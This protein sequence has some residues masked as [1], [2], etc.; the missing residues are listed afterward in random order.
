MNFFAM[1]FESPSHHPPP[2]RCCATGQEGGMRCPWDGIHAASAALAPCPTNRLDTQ[3]RPAE[4]ARH[5]RVQRTIKA[6]PTALHSPCA[7]CRW[8]PKPGPFALQPCLPRWG[9][10]PA[11]SSRTPG[12]ARG[13]RMRGAKARILDKW[14]ASAIV[15][16]FRRCKS[17]K[18]RVVALVFFEG[19]GV[20]LDVLAPNSPPGPCRSCPPR[21]RAHPRT[22]ACRCRPCSRPPARCVPAPL[23]LAR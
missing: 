19:L 18:K 17:G 12:G 9:N 16:I 22:R 13:G 23:F 2:G 14:H 10:R 7:A 1:I 5:P 6:L 11:A 21:C 15:G 4:P 20:V 8:G 3:H